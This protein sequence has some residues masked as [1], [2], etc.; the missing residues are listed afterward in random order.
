MKLALVTCSN[1][2]GWEIDDAPLHAAFERRGVTL[3]HP[4]WN[5]EAVD[6]SAF[7]AALIRTTWD[8]CDD[9]EGF[10]AWATWPWQCHATATAVPL[11]CN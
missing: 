5:D 6:W 11:Q 8:Y 9:R 7:D 2:P 3:A 1:L 4:V 10:V